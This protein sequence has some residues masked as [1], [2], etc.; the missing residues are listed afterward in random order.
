[1]RNGG[2]SCRGMSHE[3]KLMYWQNNYLRHYSYLRFRPVTSEVAGSS[4]V[5]SATFYLGARD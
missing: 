3:D 5:G 2:I 1:M 4:P